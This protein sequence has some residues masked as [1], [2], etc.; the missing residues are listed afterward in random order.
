[1]I[2]R[3]ASELRTS[4][5]EGTIILEDMDVERWSAEDRL[6]PAFFRLAFHLP[7]WILPLPACTTPLIA[8]A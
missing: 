6:Y 7:Y 2:A 8:R 4:N 5:K 3:V 1:M